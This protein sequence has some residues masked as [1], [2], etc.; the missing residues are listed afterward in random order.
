M[1]IHFKPH[2]DLFLSPKDICSFLK[3][4][5]YDTELLIGVQL[6]RLAKFVDLA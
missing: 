2:F 1:G 5:M 4:F 3:C 6:K